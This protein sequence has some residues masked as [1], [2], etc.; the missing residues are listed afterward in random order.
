MTSNRNCQVTGA[1]NMLDTETRMAYLMQ[2]TWIKGQLK[3]QHK[4]WSGWSQQIPSNQTIPYWVRNRDEFKNRVTTSN[5]HDGIFYYNC[6]K[7]RYPNEGEL[8]D[9]DLVFKF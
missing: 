6:K 8:A 7:K 2:K 1:Q 4:S 5:F 9:T 3:S